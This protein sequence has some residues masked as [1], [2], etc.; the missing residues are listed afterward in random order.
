MRARHHAGAHR[1]RWLLPSPCGPR[2]LVRADPPSTGGDELMI[3]VERNMVE[4]NDIWYVEGEPGKCWVGEDHSCITNP[5]SSACWRTH[6]TRPKVWRHRNWMSTAME[7]ERERARGA[8][9]C[10]WWCAWWC[11]WSCL[12]TALL[13]ARSNY[14]HQPWPFAPGTH[15]PT[16][17]PTA[18]RSCNEALAHSNHLSN[19]LLGMRMRLADPMP[20]RKPGPCV[21][22]WRGHH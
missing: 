15:T 17:C 7:E 8:D 14:A 1:H 12:A 6:E 19:C 9:A 21:G 16:P 22:A 18:T 20:M 13:L 4:Y 2:R 11:A 10:A 3:R 5:P